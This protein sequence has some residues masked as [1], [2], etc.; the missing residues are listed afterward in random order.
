MRANHRRADQF[1]AQLGNLQLSAIR[2]GLRQP[3]PL[4]LVVVCLAIMRNAKLAQQPLAHPFP[5]IGSS[6]IAASKPRRTGSVI[7]KLAQSPR[8]QTDD[9]GRLRLCQ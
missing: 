8:S 5:K 2:L 3:R 7:I 9:L 1:A 6:V 4:G